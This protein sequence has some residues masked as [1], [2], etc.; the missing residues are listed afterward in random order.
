MTL[1]RFAETN[2]RSICSLRVVFSVFQERSYV[3]HLLRIS[4]LKSCPDDPVSTYPK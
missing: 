3:L 1:A 4:L 2:S